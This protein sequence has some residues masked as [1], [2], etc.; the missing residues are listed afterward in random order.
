[1][2]VLELHF[3]CPGCGTFYELVR[4][5]AENDVV[6][7]ELMCLVCGASLQSR[8][9]RFVLKYFLLNRPNPQRQKSWKGAVLSSV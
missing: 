4:V 5:D 2:A 9:G 6:D 1:M 3:Q 7:R 8:E